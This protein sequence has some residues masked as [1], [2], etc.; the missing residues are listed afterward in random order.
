MRIVVSRG[1]QL[2]FA[3]DSNKTTVHDNNAVIGQLQTP[4]QMN[5]P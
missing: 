1:Q 5:N 2:S 3:Q 4:S